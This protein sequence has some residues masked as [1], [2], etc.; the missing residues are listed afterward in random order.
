M[1]SSWSSLTFP[2]DV[3]C[4][5]FCSD[6]DGSPHTAPHYCAVFV[7]EAWA[8]ERHCGALH[9]AG[10][11]WFLFQAERVGLLYGHFQNRTADFC[12]C[13][14]QIFHYIIFEKTQELLSSAI[15]QLSH[16]QSRVVRRCDANERCG[17]VG[18]VRGPSSPRQTWLHCGLPLDPRSDVHLGDGSFT[19]GGASHTEHVAAAW[20]KLSSHW[21]GAPCHA[22]VNATFHQVRSDGQRGSIGEQ[23]GA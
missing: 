2:R 23:R 3:I 12:S 10:R 19:R 5:R 16:T 1:K 18:L 6:A 7:R 11:C 4:S 22:S 20:V 17:A 8:V 21:R 15:W 14:P 9:L 13:S